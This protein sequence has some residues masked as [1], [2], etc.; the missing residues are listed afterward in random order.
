AVPYELRRE[1]YARA[2]ER[3]LADLAQLFL[4]AIETPPAADSALGRALERKGKPLT[5][6]E[7][8]QLA[9]GARRELLDRLLRDPDPQVIRLL[10]GNPRLTEPDVVVIASRRPTHRD[11]QREVFASRRWIAGYRVKRTLVLN[12]WTPTDLAIRLLTF[13][14]EPD[15]RLV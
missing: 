3:D 15:L 2:K 13:L 14:T 9:R 12:P 6:G 8:K 4:S 5:L 10:L 1:L 7:R 11:I